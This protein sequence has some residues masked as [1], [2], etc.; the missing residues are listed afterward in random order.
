[1]VSQSDLEFHRQC[2]V[3][4]DDASPSA[5]FLID[6]L[7]LD[8]H[9]VTH[10][11]DRRAVAFD[12]ALDRCH[13]FICGSGIAGMRAVNLITDLRDKAPDLPILCVAAAL[14]W[15]RRLERLLPGDVPMLH[16]PLTVGGLR[17]AVRSLLPPPSGD[18][19]QTWPTIVRDVVVQQE[20]VEGTP[21]A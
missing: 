7:R 18:S 17:A 20:T 16:E 13:L 5:A 12:L 21:A 11:I 2:V 14:R 8:G 9:R 19:M 3:V 6:A 15:T 10:L 1:M 4:A